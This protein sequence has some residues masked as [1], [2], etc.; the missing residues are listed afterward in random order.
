M[1]RPWLAA[2]GR[3][4]LVGQ[5]T[6][7]HWKQSPFKLF[8]MCFFLQLSALRN[9]RKNLQVKWYIGQAI[10]PSFIAILS[11]LRLYCRVEGD[12]CLYRR[13]ACLQGRIVSYSVIQSVSSTAGRFKIYFLHLKYLCIVVTLESLTMGAAKLLWSWAMAKCRTW[14]WWR[15]SLF[16]I[17]SLQNRPPCPAKLDYRIRKQ[18]SGECWFWAFHQIMLENLRVDLTFLIYYH[19]MICLLL[20]SH[21]FTTNVVCWGTNCSWNASWAHTPSRERREETFCGSFFLAIK[22]PPEKVF[23][24]N[25]LKWRG[26]TSCR[27]NIQLVSTLWWDDQFA[28]HNHDFKLTCFCFVEGW[29]GFQGHP[30]DFVDGRFVAVQKMTF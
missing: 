17:L 7:F 22:I 5:A 30:G 27:A 9:A 2:L 13:F 12:P 24:K 14:V 18:R 16:L 23:W 26:I 6:V 20:H 25:W 1:L 15:V 28:F 29:K 4:F 10:N 8:P 21:D 11:I 3:C 19:P